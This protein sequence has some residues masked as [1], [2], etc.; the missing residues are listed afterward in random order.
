MVASWPK[1]Q[2]VNAAVRPDVSRMA[3]SSVVDRLGPEID[4]LGGALFDAGASCTGR[5]VE[6]VNAGVS[7]IGWA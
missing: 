2:C 5:L 3:R 1:L 4:R 7:L 6:G